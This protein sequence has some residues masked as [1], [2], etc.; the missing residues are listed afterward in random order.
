MSHYFTNEEMESNL[1]KT[2]V[3]VKDKSFVFNTDNGVFSKKGLDF[4]TRVLVETLIYEN[5]SGDVL[6]V[7]CGYGPIGIILS[8]FLT[9][10][11]T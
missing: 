3:N 9:C 11:S 8:S 1:R 6:D 2:Y 7:G 4:G 5:L 10:I